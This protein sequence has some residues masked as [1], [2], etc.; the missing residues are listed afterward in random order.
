MVCIGMT[1]MVQI[2]Q[3]TLACCTNFIFNQLNHVSSAFW[4]QDVK[5]ARSSDIMAV[6]KP[7]IHENSTL[8]VYT[9]IFTKDISCMKRSLDGRV[10]W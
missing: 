4:Y 8:P 7:S 6:D 1:T 2:S 9:A 10:C 3:S 5:N